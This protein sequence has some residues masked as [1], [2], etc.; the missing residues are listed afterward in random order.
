V[1]DL[2]RNSNDASKMPL[3]LQQHPVEQFKRQVWI[4]PYYETTWAACV[5]GLDRLGS[6]SRTPGLA[7][8]LA[9]V[10]DIPEF[11]AVE[12]RAVIATTCSSSS[13]FLR[14][15]PGG[16]R[17]TTGRGGGLITSGPS[18]A[19]RPTVCPTVTDAD[20]AHRRDRRPPPWVGGRGGRRVT[21]TSLPTPGG[22]QVA[23]HWARRTGANADL[24]TNLPDGNRQ[25]A[26]RRRHR[27]PLREAPH[28]RG[29]G[30]AGRTLVFMVGGDDAGIGSG[31]C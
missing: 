26:E 17:P 12:T 15:R 1:P 14:D 7:D 30:A 3:R 2:L 20:P 4:S 19:G 6:T 28:R 10:K 22:R 27:S 31:R 11:D 5:R 21:I 16:H 23:G 13:A 29:R 25:L 9:Y 24:S 8:P 18:A